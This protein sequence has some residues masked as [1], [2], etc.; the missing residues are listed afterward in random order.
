MQQDLIKKIKQGQPQA[1]KKWFT[2]YKP[3]LMRIALTKV[4]NQADA[5]DIV[6]ET[7]INS[8]KNIHSFNE[9]SSLKTWMI[10]ILRHETAD[11][12]R[13][14]YAKKAIK[15]IPLGEYLLKYQ[16]EDSSKVNEKVKKVLGKM[17]KKRKKMLLLK[18]VDG[19]SVKEIAKKMG[20]SF[21]SIEAELYRARQSFKKSYKEI[22]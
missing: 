14:K 13:K 15:T 20:K 9:K 16:L 18:Y 10:S 7:F 1:V 22:E 8:L 21:K 5:Q 17:L 3:D 6:Q 2:L 4:S 11:Y 19:Y 12:Y